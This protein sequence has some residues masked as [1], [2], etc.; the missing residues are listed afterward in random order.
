MRS[1]VACVGL[2][3]AGGVTAANLPEVP[4][5][6]QAVS[7]SG[8]PLYAAEPSQ[9]VL[10]KLAKA[11]STYSAQPND[12]DNIIWYGRR[13]AYTGD[14][15][16]A[17]EIFSK[18]IEKFPNDDRMYRHRGHRYISIRE[19]D[20][21]IA[22]LEKASTLIEGKENETEPDGAPNVQNIPVS[23]RH[24]NIWYHLGLAYYLKQDWEN[25]F[26]AY[27][28]GFN[29]GRN[30]DNRVS[31]THW[32]Y[33]IKRR[34][35]DE[36]GANK[37]LDVITA[38]MN[39]IENFSYHHLCL[40]YK[41]EMTLQELLGDNEDTPSGA[42]AAYG[43]ANWF[44]YSGDDEKALQHLEALVETSSWSAFGVVAAEADLA[45]RE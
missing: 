37:V 42:S 22:D 8:K 5:G 13:T 44:Y 12:A 39:V 1:I 35:G 7:L 32:L 9:A 27:Q 36:E 26:R 40:F 23:S 30:D 14:Y 41:G 28:N 20:R 45:L 24:G 29:S 15:R 6:A 2:L 21:A 33:M 10:D 25:A 3:L 31:T 17:I 34:M 11:K 43:I 38:D 18:G 4:D 19:F 16:G